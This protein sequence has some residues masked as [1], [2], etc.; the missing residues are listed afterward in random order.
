MNMRLLISKVVTAIPLYGLIIWFY[1][2]SYLAFILATLTFFCALPLSLLLDMGTEET[3]LPAIYSFFW[4]LI[5]SLPFTIFLGVYAPMW[6]LS[7]WLS[8]R[9]LRLPLMIWWRGR[10]ML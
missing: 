9:M 7:F 1:H 2:F 3:S 10:V 6:V 5:I 4:H 8:E